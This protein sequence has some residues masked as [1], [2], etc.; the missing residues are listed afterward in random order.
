MKSQGNQLFK[1]D[2]GKL[3]RGAAGIKLVERIVGTLHAAIEKVAGIGGAAVVGDFRIAPV[4]RKI[5]GWRRGAALK[6]PRAGAGKAEQVKNIGS[7]AVWNAAHCMGQFVQRNAN[8]QV[9]VDVGR[10][11][12]A[13]VVGRGVV[14]RHQAPKL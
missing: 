11:G 5:G 9:R 2:R 13:A 14:G 8:Q 7:R 12:G 4:Q 10:K 6:Q 3:L 1:V